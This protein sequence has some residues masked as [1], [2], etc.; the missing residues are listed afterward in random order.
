M[1]ILGGWDWRAQSLELAAQATSRM[2]LAMPNEPTGEW[3]TPRNEGGT[4]IY[5]SLD[6]ASDVSELMGRIERTTFDAAGG[7]RPKPGFDIKVYRLT[8]ANDYAVEWTTLRQ[9][10]S[11]HSSRADS[12]TTKRNRSTARRPCS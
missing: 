4:Y 9:L 12:G 11:C 6:D 5:D 7:R 10:R 2:V 1:I 8:D 3:V